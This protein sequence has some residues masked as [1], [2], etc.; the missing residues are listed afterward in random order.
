MQRRL[1]LISVCLTLLAC[2]VGVRSAATTA[3]PRRIEITAKRFAFDPD[4]ITLKKGEP[5]VFILKSIDVPHGLRFREIGLELKA[6]K[7]KPGEVT[8]TPDRVGEFVG[9]C[10]V[11]CGAHHGSM[12]MILR[13]VN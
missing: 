3:A 11:F 4:E 13:T 1:V 9:H 7:G 5:V 6:S 10:A 2:R 12:T 8:F